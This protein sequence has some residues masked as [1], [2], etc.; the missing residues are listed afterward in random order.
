M[1]TKTFETTVE[2]NEDFDEYYITIPDEIIDSLSW[3]EGTVVEWQTNK[4]GS[5]LLSKVDEDFYEGEEDE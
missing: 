2:Y 1:T 3:D 5:I 4:D